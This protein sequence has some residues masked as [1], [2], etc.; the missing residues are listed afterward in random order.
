MSRALTTA[1]LKGILDQ[2]T[3]SV[4]LYAMIIT[5]TDLSPDLMV[6]NNSVDLDV[7]IGT[8]ETFTAFPFEITLPIIEENSVPT[9]IMRFDNIDRTL[10]ELIRTSNEKPAV[11][12]YLVRFA[13][14]DTEAAVEVGPLSFSL[15]NVKWD[16]WKIEC[17]LSI[18]YDYLNEPCMKYRFTPD[19]AI[20][21]FDLGYQAA[22]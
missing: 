16:A 3:T 4:Y 17:Q 15:I 2:T 9:A 1:G 10:V 13:P 5:H 14:G 11:E 6:I 19:I 22:T 12:L 8:V 7:D 20:G 21:L 18:E